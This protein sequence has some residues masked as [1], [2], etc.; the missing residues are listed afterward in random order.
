[1][2]AHARKFSPLTTYTDIIVNTY[3]ELA[4]IYI[5]YTCFI[6]YHFYSFIL[7]VLFA[8]REFLKV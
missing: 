3:S 5:K 6:K 8:H 4:F 2:D 7:L 1:M